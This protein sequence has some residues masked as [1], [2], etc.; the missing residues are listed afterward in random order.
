MIAI[1]RFEPG[2]I[3]VILPIQREELGLP[4]TAEDQPRLL[5]G[6]CR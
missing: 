6:S 4:V 3:A 1:S 5:A 2:V